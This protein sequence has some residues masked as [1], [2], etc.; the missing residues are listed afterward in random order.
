M[1][2]IFKLEK[3]KDHKIIKQLHRHASVKVT[4]HFIKVAKLPICLSMHQ[5]FASKEHKCLNQTLR[6]SLMVDAELQ[7]LN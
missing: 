2:L 1:Q 6:K 4:H 5:R 3:L 7:D